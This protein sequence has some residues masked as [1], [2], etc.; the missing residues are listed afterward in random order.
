MSR[1]PKTLT[2]TQIHQLLDALLVKHGTRKQ[3]ARSIRNYAMACCMLEAGLRVGEVVQLRRRDLWFNSGPVKSIIVRAEIAKNKKERQLPVS[4]RLS[5]AIKELS[6]YFWPDHFENIDHVAFFQK[7]SQTTIT[8]RQVERIVCAAA[9]SSIGRPIHP[10]VLRHTFATRLMKV[11]DIRTVQ[12]MLGH[13]S[14]TS[15]Q[16]YTHPDEHDKSKAITEMEKNDKKLEEELGE[17][18]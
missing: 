4:T 3:F 18:T 7:D 6:T 9:E 13:R 15:T 5:D 14:I 8:T 16:I 10:H 12:E 11:T 17:S 1:T 2:V